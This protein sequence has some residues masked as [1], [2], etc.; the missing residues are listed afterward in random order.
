MSLSHKYDVA[1]SFAE[2][3]RD[4]AVS[5][6]LAMEAYK[7]KHYYYPYNY[8]I[9]L[10]YSLKE[11]LP[12]I[13]EFDAKYAL[14]LFSKNY[15]SKRFTKIELDAIL[16]RT[17]IEKGYLLPIIV[18]NIH[19]NK[20]EE[21]SEDLT[22]LKWNKDPKNIARL[23]CKKVEGLAIDINFNP[24]DYNQL[25]Q[26]YPEQLYKYI[27]Y[28]QKVVASTQ[29]NGS[30]FLSLGI[31]YLH[32]KETKLAKESLMVALNFKVDDPDIYYFAI[33][34]LLQ[35]KPIQSISFQD[36]KLAV[37]W[38]T[39]SL[40]LN[41]NQHIYYLLAI[42]LEN[43]YFKVRGLKSNLPPNHYLNSQIQKLPKNISEIERL[44]YT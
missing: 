44:N 31:L 21:L 16:R 4:I 27:N 38:L 18:D 25:K 41:A 20:I 15:L 3:E 6:A 29:K 40:Q 19:L 12:Q 11:K 2:E 43:K 8:E 24:K 36:A 28:Y 26:L 9:T 35:G 22:Y 42:I 37:E 30:D 14:V 1:L 7:L 39:K 34:S 33:L 23:V 13:Y 32:I 10:G 5:I 17:N